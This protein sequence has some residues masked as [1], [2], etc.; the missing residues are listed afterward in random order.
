MNA[1]NLHNTSSTLNP[2]PG[3][4]KESHCQPAEECEEESTY[5]R[6]VDADGPIF[7]PCCQIQLLGRNLSIVHPKQMR[8]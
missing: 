1:V 2:Q 6:S 3:A 8:S 7:K 4:E 5:R